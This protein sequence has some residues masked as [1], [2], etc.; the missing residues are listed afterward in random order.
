MIY[1]EDEEE[2]QVEFFI[3]AFRNQNELATVNFPQQIF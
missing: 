3:N 1:E 2:E